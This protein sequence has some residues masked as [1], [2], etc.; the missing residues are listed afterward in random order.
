SLLWCSRDIQLQNCREYSPFSGLSARPAHGAGCGPR[1]YSTELAPTV[2]MRSLPPARIS[3][4]SRLGLDRMERSPHRRSD[5]SGFWL[6]G[7][8]LVALVLIAMPGSNIR[9]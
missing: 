7:S 8:K 9:L 1:A 4:S 5:S 3:R 6:I 2:S